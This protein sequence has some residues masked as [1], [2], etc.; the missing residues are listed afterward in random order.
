ML[1]RYIMARIVHLTSVHSAFDTRI[2]YRECQSLANKGHEV[3]LIAPHDRDENVEGILISAIPRSRSRWERTSSSI[4]RIYRRAIRY[5]ADLYHFHDP[6]LIPI[7]LLLRAHGKNVICDIHEDLPRTIADKQYLPAWLRPSVAWLSEMFE[8]ATCKYFSALITATEEIAERYRRAHPNTNL[9][10]TFPSPTELA[11]SVGIPWG[12][13]N[14]AVAYVGGLAAERGIIE[15]I[16]AMSLVPAHLEAQ[17]LLAG[18]FIPEEL[19]RSV[20]ELPGWSRTKYEGFLKRSCIAKLLS[21]VRVGLVVLHPAPNFL[22]SMPI[23]LF[24]Y[25]AAGIPVIAS[26]FP[27]W[28][29]IVCGAGCGLLVNP[30]DPQEIASAI[31][32]LL[33]NPDRAEQMGKCGRKAVERRY[34]WESQEAE[35]FR[36]YGELLGKIGPQQKT[37]V[38]LRSPCALGKKEN[39]A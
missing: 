9:V 6:E 34:N 37:P 8:D 5:N 19:R 1:A 3:V 29:E 25:M 16:T 22:R 11:S 20:C 17:L 39:A 28:R 33:S 4:W 24:E 31:T 30:C 38:A 35:L 18:T 21:R 13:R 27:I 14:M 32:F 7:G 2:F 15:I 10:M 12:M 23:K 36:V 26:D